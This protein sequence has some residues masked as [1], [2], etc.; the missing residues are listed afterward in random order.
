M[1]LPLV[2]AIAL[3][4]C[5]SG[6]AAPP[7]S[8][9]PA[10]G[11]TRPA[12]PVPAVVEPGS[13]YAKDVDKLCNALTLSGAMDQPEEAR[14][15]TVAKWLGANLETSEVHTFLV[16][17]QGLAPADKVTALNAEAKKVGLDGCA[18]SKAWEK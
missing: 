12:P 9:Q 2:A 6:S 5:Q 14:Q 11:P 4:A 17:L 8:K 3:A 10:A 18:L 16:K 7:P 15:L 1:R 13:A